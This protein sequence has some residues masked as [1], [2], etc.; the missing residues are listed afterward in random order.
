VNPELEIAPPGS[1]M[2]EQA[3]LATKA[4]FARIHAL[5]RAFDTGAA[6]A[7]HDEQLPKGVRKTKSPEGATIFIV[8]NKSVAQLTHPGPRLKEVVKPPAGLKIP[9]AASGG[10]YCYL[11]PQPA[12]LPAN[13][14]KLLLVD[15][16][17]T[18]SVQVAYLNPES[19]ELSQTD[20]RDAGKAA[21]PDFWEE[22]VW[23]NMWMGTAPF[24]MNTVTRMITLDDPKSCEFPKGSAGLTTL[25]YG[26]ADQ[27]YLAGDTATWTIA[28]VTAA[29]YTELDRMK[30]TKDMLPPEVWTKELNRYMDMLP[31]PHSRVTVGT[32][33]ESIAQRYINANFI[34]GFND[35]RREYIGCMGPKNAT[36]VNFWRMINEQK[37]PIVVM[38]TKFTE[39]EKDKCFAYLPT[40]VGESLEFG[41]KI[42]MKSSVKHPGY[43]HSVLS[44]VTTTGAV[45]EVHH[46]WYDTWPDHGVPTKNKKPNA[47]NVLRM[48]EEIEK[49]RVRMRQQQCGGELGP[50]AVHCSAGVGRTG[51][52]IA[53]DHA[54]NLLR[55]TGAVDPASVI[56]F[57][58][59]DRCVL[60][61]H[62][63]QFEFFNAA[64]H[65]YAKAVGRKLVRADK[66][67][68]T[69]PSL[70]ETYAML[71]VELAK[72]EA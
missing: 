17:G 54:R 16:L 56:R 23:H 59:Q 24:W 63:E 70:L 6:P 46:F 40:A 33:K 52:I 2:P 41:C 26:H 12:G 31:L 30:P 68:P 58:R 65:S 61:Q 44:I 39:K 42:E 71:D 15:A 48:L 64:L 49:L 72:R 20:P 7:Q 55:H 45:R 19:G 14:V 53:I 13:C 18:G 51:T 8:H 27:K 29:S 28:P 62:L 47:S 57:I 60:V 34:R 66:E 9:K 43:L 36:V 32:T 35:D 25:C 50:T 5:C 37:V 3:L 11:E 67:P 38:L 69:T 1:P 21:L 10:T 4:E 22:G